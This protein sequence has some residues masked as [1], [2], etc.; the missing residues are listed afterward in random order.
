MYQHVTHQVSFPKVK[1]MLREF[2]GIHMTLS[3]VH[4]M[5]AM[6]AGFYRPTY[7]GILQ[8]LLAGGVIHVD[9]T[10]FI[11]K[12]GSGYVW[13][14]ANMEDVYFFYRPSREGAFL[15]EMLGTFEGVLVS[16]FYAAYDSVPCAQQKCLVHLIRDINSDV[17]K[18]PFDEELKAVIDS[19]ARGY[20]QDQIETDS[21]QAGP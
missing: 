20:G 16:D 11:L 12:S 6:L 19:L 8:R 10:E 15:K 5:K 17:L 18:N 13:V 3:Y 2:F 21:A 7:R 4:L 14:L 9:E 1:T